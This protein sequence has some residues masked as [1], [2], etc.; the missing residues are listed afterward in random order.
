VIADPVGASNAARNVASLSIDGRWVLYG[1]MGGRI[2]ENFDLGALVAKR[3]AL[4]STT[5]KTRSKDYKKSLLEEMSKV[6][7]TSGYPFRPVTDKIIPM[8]AAAEAHA[9]MESN[10]T[11]GKVLLK[12]DLF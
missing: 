10:T 1:S 2:V 9:L 3:G 4:L 8:S 7:F 12:Q 5:L 6:F 11:V